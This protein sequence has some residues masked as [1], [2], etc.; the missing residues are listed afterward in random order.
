MVKK[1]TRK[2]TTT[3]WFK[4]RRYGW[5][6]TPVTWQGWLVIITFVLGL[7][8]AARKLPDDPSDA[9]ESQLIKFF[10]TLGIAIILL[11]TVSLITGPKP[12]WRWGKKPTD[13]PDEDY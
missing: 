11:I 13:N 10:V 9:S 3:Y 1:K 4:R 7:I 12:H 6:Y 8:S 5:G 2:P